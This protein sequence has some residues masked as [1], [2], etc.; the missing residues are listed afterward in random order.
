[1]TRIKKVYSLFSKKKPQP[2]IIFACVYFP[3]IPIWKVC[4][5]KAYAD[6]RFRYIDNGHE[7]IAKRYNVRYDLAGTTRATIQKNV[8]DLNKKTLE[9]L[10]F[11]PHVPGYT[12][13]WDLPMVESEDD[14]LTIELTI[15]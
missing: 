6:G 9:S 5:G 14:E 11:R 13:A 12:F 10:Y 1:M 2:G 7:S 15:D 8:I 3:S 4:Q